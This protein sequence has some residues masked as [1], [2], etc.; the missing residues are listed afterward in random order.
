LGLSSFPTPGQYGASSNREHPLRNLALLTILSLAALAADIPITGV[1]AVSTSTSSASS[2]GFDCGIQVSI[3]CSGA[4]TSYRYCDT[5]DTG[6]TCTAVTTDLILNQ[7][8]TYDI[9]I[10]ERHS[11]G[12]QCKLAFITAA[13]SG[14]CSIKSVQPRSIP[15]S[16]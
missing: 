8:T 2:A 9:A 7:S 16:L 10:P 12:G 11:S 6:A 14:S 4:D 5:S 15:P 13:G 3:R 1:S